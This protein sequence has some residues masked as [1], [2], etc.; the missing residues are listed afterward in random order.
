MPDHLSE[1]QIKR[2]RTR[3]IPPG[4]LF[5]VD[6]H[7]SLCTECRERLASASDLR[8]AFLPTPSH[9][10]A[11][12]SDNASTGVGS[13]A[14]WLGEVDPR[15]LTYEQIETFVDGKASESEGEAVRRH[16]EFC[17]VCAGEIRDLSAFKA[18]L[19]APWD[20][21]DADERGKSWAVFRTLW[22]SRP[23]VALALA[24][25]AVIIL[26][27]AVEK[28][29][30]APPREV[31][32]K[33]SSKPDVGSSTPA[34]KETLSAHSSLIH[35]INALPPEEHA[36]VLEAAS[37]QKIKS[38]DVLAELRGR[39]ET[40]LGE[41]A[42]GARFDLLAP[43]G[44]VVSE[45]RP[46]FRWQPLANTSNYSL[47]IFDINLNPVQSSPPL[48]ATQWKAVRPLK[49]G[50]IYLWQV[51]ANLSHGKSVSSPIPPSPEAK[52]QVLDQKKADELTGF[53]K[54]HPEAHLALGIMY[55]QAG[56]LE[57]GEH[58]LTNI[59]ESD[60]DYKL[61]QNLLNSVQGIRHP[62]R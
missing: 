21:T 49:R 37:Q 47:A 13:H 18:E 58:E 50:Q 34:G 3:Q 48:Q 59:P 11:G 45:E 4:E 19:A 14:A 52:F 42:K 24:M 20:K 17:S 6:D 43:V 36:A 55:A 27:V 15:H 39:Q 57:Q 12:S 8:L 2:Y 44:E 30:L 35:A 5:V 56:L 60:P 33:G 29:R 38:P 32:S 41:T 53:Q 54:A 1:E 9:S 61:A 22:L 62:R 31:P 23:R 46:I 26:V 7:I 10:L 16:V 28:S 51:T 25:S 40:L